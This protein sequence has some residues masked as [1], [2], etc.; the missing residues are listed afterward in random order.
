MF[1]KNIFAERLKTLRLNNNI[2]SVE[3]ANVVGVSKA[4]IS[5]F[6]NA[7]NSPNCNTLV[8]IADYFDVSLD[9]LV[10]RS[11]DPSRH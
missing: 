2:S 4:A 11:E 10:G 6:E 9:Y 1:N 3:L 5:Q 8:S 7:V